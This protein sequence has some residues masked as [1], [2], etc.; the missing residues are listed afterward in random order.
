MKEKKKLFI[1][2]IIILV[3]FFTIVYMLYRPKYYMLS[4]RNG[5]TVYDYADGILV[6]NFFKGS[7]YLNV[8][9]DNPDN[10][11]MVGLFIY[12]SEL[13]DF[14]LLEAM[15]GNSMGECNAI[16]TSSGYSVTNKVFQRVEKSFRNGNIINQMIDNM[17]NTYLCIHDSDI[18]EM[19]I[20][21]CYKIDF[22][23]K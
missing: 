4:V 10:H 3:M 6:K 17:E 15:G 9:F 18:Y 19:T 16:K 23:L 8:N 7:F 5:K 20:D 13:D 14:R 2:N 21:D 12:D 11:C 1:V 22:K